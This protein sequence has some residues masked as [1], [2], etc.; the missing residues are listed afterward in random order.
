MASPSAGE[1]VSEVGVAM[2]GGVKLQALASVIHAYPTYS[3]A[4]QQI[5]AEVKPR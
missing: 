1:L 5:A 2:A 3:I 4:L